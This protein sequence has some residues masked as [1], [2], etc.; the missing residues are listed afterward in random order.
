MATYRQVIVALNKFRTEGKFQMTCSDEWTDWHLTPA[1]WVEGSEMVDFGNLRKKPV[2][3][4]RVLTRRR[5]EVQTSPY[6]EMHRYIKTTWESDERETI[7]T[8][9]KQYGECPE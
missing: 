4:D 7:E 1:G 6:S 5:G 8:L 2:P 9:L 3:D